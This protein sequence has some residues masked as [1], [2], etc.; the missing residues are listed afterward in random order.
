[1]FSYFQKIQYSGG[2]I[3]KE[4]QEEYEERNF[5]GFTIHAQEIF[6]ITFGCSIGV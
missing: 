2:A 4:V 1:M 5:P 6:G 3:S